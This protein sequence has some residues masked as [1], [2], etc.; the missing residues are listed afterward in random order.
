MARPV[1]SGARFSHVAFSVG[2]ARGKRAY[3]LCVVK[4]RQGVRPMSSVV[5]LDRRTPAM[6]FREVRDEESLWGDLRPELAAAV[7]QILHATMEDELTVLLAAR[8]YERTTCRLDQ[9]NGHYRRWLLTGMGA[10]E[11]AVPRTRRKNRPVEVQP[12][13]FVFLPRAASTALWLSCA[14]RTASNSGR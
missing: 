7:S 1:K 10:V 12:S 2:F 14:V 13:P 11:L 8:R 4:A 5:A 3:Y 9:R 6:R